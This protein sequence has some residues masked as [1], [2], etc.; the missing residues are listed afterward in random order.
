[1]LG[2]AAL[3]GA[4][5]ARHPSEVLSRYYG[6]AVVPETD[7]GCRSCSTSVRA[8]GASLLLAQLVGADRLV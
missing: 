6:A 7:G 3:C 8:A 2:G 1:M 4:L 5:L